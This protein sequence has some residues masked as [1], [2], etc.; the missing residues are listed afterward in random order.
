MCSKYSAYSNK[1]W[2]SWRKLQIDIF[3]Y[4]ISFY[5]DIAFGFCL[6]TVV[7][8][9][10]VGLSVVLALS[11][12]T[13]NSHLR[14]CTLFELHEPIFIQMFLEIKNI[15]RYFWFKAKRKLFQ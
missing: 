7:K 9:G 1:K 15:W 12:Q 5:V 8:G 3:T 2:R 14:A 11:L 6:F 4:D 13:V 10:T